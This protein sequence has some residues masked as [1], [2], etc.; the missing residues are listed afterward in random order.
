MN[1]PRGLLAL[2][3]ALWFAMAAAPVDVSAQADPFLGTFSA[4]GLVVVLESAGNGYAGRATLAG[5]SFRVTGQPVRNGT[6]RGSYDYYGTAIS[7]ELTASERG[8]IVSSE[9]ERFELFRQGPATGASSQPQ[10]AAPSRPL[11]ADEMGDAQWGIR[12]TVPEGWRGVKDG[13]VFLL[14]SDETAGL[15]VLM[16]HEATTIADLE[17]GAREGLVDEGTRLR[18]SGPVSRRAD[19]RGVTARFTGQ[20]DGA[21][22]EAYAVGV[23]PEHDLGV[24]VIAATSPEAFGEDHIGLADEIAQ[25]VEFAEPVVPPITME[26]RRDLAGYR[27]TYLWSYD[28]GV[29]VDGSYSGGS[30]RTVIDL[31]EPGHFSYYNSSSMSVDSG[32][33]D[34]AVSVGGGG[35]Q[36][37]LGRWSIVTYSDGPY[38]K[39]EFNDGDVLEYGLEW[40]DSALYMD[41]SRYFR[42]NGSYNPDDGPSC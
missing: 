33:A 20:V 8:I 36:E 14:G 25:S 22:A 27:L 9:G 24:V 23:L 16:P 4:D 18:L 3:V 35:S 38:L 40:N 29:S 13:G 42:T 34:Y 37:G 12:F 15:I 28:S 17:A 10:G 7:F 19:G 30:Q 32:G 1:T 5:E 26:W 31:C 2:V 6:V 39:L 21:P 41:G 11:G